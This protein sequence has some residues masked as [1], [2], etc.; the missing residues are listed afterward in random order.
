VFSVKVL[1]RLPIEAARE[2]K[3]G[4]KLDHEEGQSC[5][6]LT[7]QTWAGADWRIRFLSEKSFVGG[8]KSNSILPDFEG[9]IFQKPRLIPSAI[10]TKPQNC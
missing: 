8:L 9:R 6:L 2:A 7:A 1:A 3:T 10:R 5:W 4:R